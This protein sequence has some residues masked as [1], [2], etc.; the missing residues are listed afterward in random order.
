MDSV[1]AIQLIAMNN[2]IKQP[3]DYRLRVLQRWYS[4]TFFTPL[5]EVEEIPLEDLLLHFYE[6]QYAELEEPE[7]KEELDLLLESPEDKLK[8]EQ[9]EYENRYKSDKDD[10]KWVE[11]QKKEVEAKKALIKDKP[12]DIKQVQKGLKPP[13]EIKMTFSEDFEKELAEIDNRTLRKDK[14]KQE[15]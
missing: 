8:R 7:R 3:P 1:K 2:I 13:E 15:W 4:K 6:C 10:E 5:Q 12:I 14:K 9:K 11:A